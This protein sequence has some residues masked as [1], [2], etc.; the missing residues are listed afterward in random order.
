MLKDT[1][2]KLKTY[3]CSSVTAFENLSKIVILCGFQNLRS[4]PLFV[5][6]SI[7][8][9]LLFT[10]IACWLAISTEVPLKSTNMIFLNRIPSI[11]LFQEKSSI[12]FKCVWIGRACLSS[13]KSSWNIIENPIVWKFVFSCMVHRIVNLS[14]HL[15][16]QTSKKYQNFFFKG[17]WIVPISLCHTSLQSSPILLKNQ[18]S[19]SKYLC[20]SA[21]TGVSGLAN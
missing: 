18:S 3:E 2:W 7:H 1:T 5:T 4:F 19:F 21:K 9:W 16:V 12:K 11:S 13:R 10:L 8:S 15:G 17:M 6:I 20:Q 14:S